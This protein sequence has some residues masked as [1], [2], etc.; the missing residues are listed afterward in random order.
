MS[1]NFHFN[2]NYFKIYNKLLSG[3]RDVEEAKFLSNFIPTK[4]SEV[5]DL[6]CGW[7][8]HL[9]ELAGLGFSN[10]TGVDYAET[11]LGKAK[12]NL[13]DY[14]YIELVYSTFMD[15]KSKKKFDLVFQVFQAFGY[16]S[17][18]YDRSNLKNVNSLLSDEGVYLLD[19]RN[20][21]LLRSNEKF[22]LPNEIMVEASFNPKTRREK[23]TYHFDG[24]KDIG[25]FNVYSLDELKAL[26]NDAG[27]KIVKT[28]G[29]YKGE[30][31]GKATERLM[32]LARK[33]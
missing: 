19:L 31:Y 26:F 22:D 4:R 28:F 11:L 3:K 18:E 33:A 10:L 23:F 17:V 15:F 5:L 20:P 2:E 27:L 7:G 16:E 29:S 14:P 24:K 8:R 32:V 12:E 9:K 13:Q 6:G 30:P 25:E 1:W 21:Q